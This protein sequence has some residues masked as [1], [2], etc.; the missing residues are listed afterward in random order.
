VQ[1]STV[2]FSKPS[3]LFR[4]KGKYLTIITNAGGPGVISTDSLIASGGK[5]AWISDDTMKQL[6][7]ILPSHWSHANPIDILGDASE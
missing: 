2:A 6:N 1:F 7:D 4:P 3:I 5:L